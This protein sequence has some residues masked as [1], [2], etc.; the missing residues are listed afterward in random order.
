MERDELLALEVRR[1][2]IIK[3]VLNKDK[4][5]GVGNFVMLALALTDNL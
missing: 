3:D 1:R 5:W 2:R 4:K